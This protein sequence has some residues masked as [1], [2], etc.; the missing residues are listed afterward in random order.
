MRA[1]ALQDFVAVEIG[2]LHIQQD[3]IW[4]VAC[5]RQQTFCTGLSQMQPEVW[6]ARHEFADDEG[7]HRVVFDIQDRAA[8]RRRARWLPGHLCA[9]N[10][11]QI[12]QLI[13]QAEQMLP[14]LVHMFEP[15][16]LGL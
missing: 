13:D 10:F 9:L 6:P 5:S 3:Q 7:I 15:S 11:G 1:K 12:E 2:Q 16:A 4:Q 8:R 14:G